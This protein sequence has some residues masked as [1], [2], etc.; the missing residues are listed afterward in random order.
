MRFIVLAETF[1]DDVFILLQRLMPGWPS[2]L[3]PGG[4]GTQVVRSLEA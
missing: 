1:Y 4:H 2:V 3:Y